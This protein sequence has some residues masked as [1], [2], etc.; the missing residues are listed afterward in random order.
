[1]T[2]ERKGIEVAGPPDPALRTSPIVRA[3]ETIANYN[4]WYNGKQYSNG[5][6]LCQL[7]EIFQ[8]SYGVWIDQQR[9]CGSSQ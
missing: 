6:L 8:C 7:G 2:D 4:C 3:G 9:S 1:M 5:A